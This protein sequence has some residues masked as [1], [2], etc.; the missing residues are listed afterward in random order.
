MFLFRYCYGSSFELLC[1]SDRFFNFRYK[2]WNY[3]F[4]SLRDMSLLQVKADKPISCKE[5]KK[6]YIHELSDKL[7]TEWIS[8]FQ[9][10]YGRLDITCW[11]YHVRPTPDDILLGYEIH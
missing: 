4:A 3:C 9:F 10:G 11:C 7:Y 1:L 6:I 8:N 5:K 2:L